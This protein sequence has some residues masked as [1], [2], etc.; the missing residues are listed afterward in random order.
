MHRFK[1]RAV[2]EPP[3][4]LSRQL[5]TGLA[6]SSNLD[7]VLIEF[8]EDHLF[9]CSYTSGEIM[10]HIFCDA[11]LNIKGWMVVKKEDRT[12]AGGL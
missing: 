8:Q 1:L 3:R 6:W 2:Q 9:V 7:R 12:K 11:N 5:Q 4:P 10:S